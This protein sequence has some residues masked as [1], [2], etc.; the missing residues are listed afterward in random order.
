MRNLKWLILAAGVL[1]ADQITKFLVLCYVA[2]PIF[3]TSFF[4]LIFTGN[5]GAAFSF[6]AHA[7]GWQMWLFGGIAVVISIILIIWLYLLP[8]HKIW[9]PISLMLI[10]GGALGNLLDRIMHGFVV[11]FLYFHVD[12]WSWPAFNLA[13]TAIVIGAIMLIIEVLWGKKPTRA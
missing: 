5:T 1:I 2:K 3:I 11:D 6:L 10:L 12:K 4:S 8:R 7:S 13:D 9:L